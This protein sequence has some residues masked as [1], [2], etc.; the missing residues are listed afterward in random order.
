MV[1]HLAL[2][3]KVKVIRAPAQGIAF[4]SLSMSFKHPLVSRVGFL[5]N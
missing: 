5:C 1:I 4:T 2:M 3:H